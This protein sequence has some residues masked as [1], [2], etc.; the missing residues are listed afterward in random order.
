MSEALVE[1]FK[2]ELNREAELRLSKNFPEHLQAANQ[3][4]KQPLFD[5]EVNRKKAREQSAT[6]L[7]AAETVNTESI[8]RTKTTVSSNSLIDEAYMAVK[9][10]L[11][12]LGEDVQLLRMWVMMNVP[13]IEDGN[14]FGVSVQ[15]EIIM[16]AAKTE[17]DAT[18]ML[19]F[20]CDYLSFR[21]KL[22]TKRLKWPGV[23]DYERAISDLDETT[24]I[25]L[26]MAVQ[27]IRN[28]YARMYDL[29]SKNADKIRNPRSDGMNAVNIMY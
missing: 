6:P 28:N 24:Y 9:P 22:C 7:T 5:I 14:N 21:G 11:L 15:E 20:Y 3:L 25:R 10:L 8:P 26:R 4:L 18:T 1:S 16:E 2:T 29:F 27:D 17:T 13:R 12:Q 19:D 23:A